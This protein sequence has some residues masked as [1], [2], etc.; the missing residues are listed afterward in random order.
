MDK[1][2]F[3]AFGPGRA[4]QAASDTQSA[5]ESYADTVINGA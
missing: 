5:E 4:R 3:E 2:S 1:R